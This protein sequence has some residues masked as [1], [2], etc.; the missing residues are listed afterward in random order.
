MITHSM[1][2]LNKACFATMG[3]FWVVGTEQRGV[4]WYGVALG[5]CGVDIQPYE[6]EG[7]WPTREEALKVILRSMSDV[8][9]IYP[10][11]NAENPGSMRCDN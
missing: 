3:A 1:D 6:T 7:G 9:P 11:L 4:L 5:V 2:E 8:L 10:Y